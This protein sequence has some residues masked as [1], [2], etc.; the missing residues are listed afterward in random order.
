LTKLIYPLGLRT[1]CRPAPSANSGLE[2]A[3]NPGVNAQLH[4]AT[5]SYTEAG[6]DPGARL[7]L[8]IGFRPAPPTWWP[9]PRDYGGL[10]L[11]GRFT[12]VVGTDVRRVGAWS[13]YLRGTERHRTT[14][15]CDEC[16]V[17]NAMDAMWSPFP[18][19]LSS[20]SRTKLSGVSLGRRVIRVI[21]RSCRYTHGTYSI[22]NISYCALSS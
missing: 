4:P 19:P 1:I 8:F 10:E 3:L 17:M 14:H 7:G 13:K 12:T 11:R 5:P 21:R 2:L 6:G 18:S 22:F 20:P 9:E 16:P 15:R